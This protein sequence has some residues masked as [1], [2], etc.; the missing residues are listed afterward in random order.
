LWGAALVGSFVQARTARRSLVWRSAFPE[1][2]PRAGHGESRA[3]SPEGPKVTRRAA[4]RRT[5]RTRR[6]G[7]ASGGPS[8]VITKVQEATASPTLPK[9]TRDRVPRHMKDKKTSSESVR[10]QPQATSAAEVVEKSKAAG[11]TYDGSMAGK[12][13]RRGPK[14]GHAKTARTARRT[15]TAPSLRSS[16]PVQSKAEFVRT[17]PSSTPANEVVAKA[18]AA[19][20]PITK[21][22]VYS[23]RSA[24]KRAKKKGAAKGNAPKPAVIAA[25]VVTGSASAPKVSTKAELLL[26]AVG[27]EIGLGNAIALLQSERAR[28]RELLGG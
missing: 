19:G 2:F 13:R 5:A 21:D 6:P 1:G 23:V 20:L 10:E 4:S 16:K 15:S 25:A 8:R 9:G 18:K 24:D 3:L 27:A 17:L 28:V 14:D 11:S 22:Y 12:V 7:E 26:K